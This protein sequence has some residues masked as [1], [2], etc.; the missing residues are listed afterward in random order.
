MKQKNNKGITLIALV[1]TVIVLLILTL[2]GIRLVINGGIITKSKNATSEYKISEEKEKI[3]LGHKTYQ[4]EKIEGTDNPVLTV[5]GAD[6]SGNDSLG[7]TIT[8]KD[9]K[10]IYAL[11]PDGSIITG[12]TIFDAEEW[13]KTATS[14]YLFIWQSD[15]PA[16]EGYHVIKGWRKTEHTTG[17]GGTYYVDDIPSEIIIPSRCTKI[18]DAA[19]R[20]CNTIT[21]VTIPKSVTSIGRCAFI[22]CKN[23]VQVEVTCDF[24]S[25]MGEGVFYGT[26]W[27][28]NQPF[29]TLIYLGN[30]LYGYK[31]TLS[32]ENATLNVKDG[33]RIIADSAL[34]GSGYGGPYNS[35]VITNIKLPDSITYIGKYAFGKCE[36]LTRINI[37]IGVTYIGDHAFSRCTSLTN[38]ILPSSV[39]YVGSYAFYGWTSSQIVYLKDGICIDS[40]NSNWDRTGSTSTAYGYTTYNKVSKVSKYTEN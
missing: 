14:E 7:W 2:A 34:A 21:K 6:V 36:G 22:N 25:K 5:E 35:K 30:V 12:E 13:D 10:N 11:N 26:P 31:G 29:D 40:W 9:T 33:T 37:P 4:L 3:Q 23:L 27:Y 8:F 19:F 20:L 17:S 32:M 39:S 24:G 16:S 1:I 15:D 28:N 18:S 38:V